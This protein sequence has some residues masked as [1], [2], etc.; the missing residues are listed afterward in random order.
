MFKFHDQ[1]QMWVNVTG[2]RK[3]R[4]FLPLLRIK[5]QKVFLPNCGRVAGINNQ[6]LAEAKVATDNSTN[7]HCESSMRTIKKSYIMK[8]GLIRTSIDSINTRTLPSKSSQF[9]THFQV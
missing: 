3:C 5:N 1:P 7:C 8:K 2:S 4:I 6:K 9:Q